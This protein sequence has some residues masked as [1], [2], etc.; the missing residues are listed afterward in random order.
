[1][2]WFRLQLHLILILLKTKSTDVE[3]AKTK[4][5]LFESDSRRIT[6]TSVFEASG[7]SRARV[8]V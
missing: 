2:A 4:V 3:Q 8:R 5:I 7:Q 1:M 6:N